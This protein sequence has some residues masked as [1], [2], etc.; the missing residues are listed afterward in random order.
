MA[1]KLSPFFEKRC[2][3][4]PLDYYGN[5]KKKAVKSVVNVKTTHSIFEIVFELAIGIIGTVLNIVKDFSIIQSGI[6]QIIGFMIT[7]FILIISI[8]YLSY[9]LNVYKMREVYFYYF[10]FSNLFLKPS[11]NKQQYKKYI[12]NF[13]ITNEN[14]SYSYFEKYVYKTLLIEKVP[15]LQKD[16]EINVKDKKTTLIINGVKDEIKTFEEASM[17]T[18]FNDFF[19]WSSK[20]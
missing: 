6:R 15:A 18:S 16:V 11:T 13:E 10:I 19:H 20:A 3:V 17:I 7:S 9:C 2:K 12:F 14:G 1:S 8:A 5:F 4:I